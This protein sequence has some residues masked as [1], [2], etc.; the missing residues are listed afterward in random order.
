MWLLFPPPPPLLSLYSILLPF[1]LSPPSPPIYSLSPSLL[2]LSPSSSP[3]TYIP[4]LL[5]SFL[6]LLLLPLPVSNLFSIPPPLLP[7]ISLPL[8]PYYIFSLLLSPLHFL[9]PPTYRIFKS[10]RKHE[11]VKRNFLIANFELSLIRELYLIWIYEV[12]K[13]SEQNNDI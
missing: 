11:K 3:S 5:P 12:V 9:P 10:E 4:L 1:P 8:S 13:I 7:L 2:P 6:P